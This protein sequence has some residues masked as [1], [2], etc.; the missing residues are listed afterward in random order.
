MRCAIYTRISRDLT[1]EQV[2]ADRQLKECR[3]LADSGGHELVATYRDNDVSAY[4]GRARPDFEKLLDAMAAGDFSVLIVW[5]IDRL[6]RSMK[7]LERIIDVAEGGGIQIQTVSSGDL[8]LSTSAGRMIGRILGSVAR[9]ES[10]HHAER[11]KLANKEHALAGRWCSTG[12]RP[13]GYDKTGVPLEPEATMLRHAATDVLAGKSLHAVAREWNASGVTTVRGAQWTNLHVRRVL[14]N[15]RLA[16]LRVHRGE[17]IGQGAWEPIIDEGIWRGLWAFLRDPERRNAVAFERRHMLSGIARCGLCK[18]PLYVARPHG[19]D[20]PAAYVCRRPGAHVGRNQAA[21]DGY[22]E[23]VVLGYLERHG[24][25]ADLRRGQDGVDFDGLRAERE[26][27]ATTK[28]QLATLLRTGVLDMAAVERESAVLTA[29][30][31]AIDRRLADAV[32]SP[33][34]LALLAGEDDPAALD[35]DKLVERWL[36][37]SPDLRGKI[38]NSLFEVVVNP[39]RKG[40]RN[41]DPDFVEI[42]WR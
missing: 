5:H 36:A 1:G 32:A 27:K 12:S 41:F 25:G 15:A 29:E 38:V 11:R 30:I 31:D 19:R 3:E 17:I 14:T 42:N 4:S 18:G 39:V 13:F 26:A 40:V 20:R 10:E 6:Y 28:D 34:A 7:D 35:T 16:A 33:P 37:A 21:L 9:Q 23:R 24:L 8:D 22:V 2:G